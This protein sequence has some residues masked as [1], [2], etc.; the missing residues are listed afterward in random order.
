VLRGVDAGLVAAAGIPA[1][2]PGAIA[3]VHEAQDVTVRIGAPRAVG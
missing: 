1:P 2:P 3:L